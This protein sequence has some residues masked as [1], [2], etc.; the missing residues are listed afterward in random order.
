M[1]S[2]EKLVEAKQ[3][4]RE[5][6]AHA[7]RELRYALRRLRHTSRESELIEFLIAMEEAGALACRLYDTTHM[8][9]FLWF[10]MADNAFGNYIFD[11]EDDLTADIVELFLCLELDLEVEVRP[12]PKLI[13]R[14]PA[15]TRWIDEP[16]ER[17]AEIVVAN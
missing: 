12:Q 14:K 8:P 11:L 6:L 7:H 16:D 3:I 17:V 15:E 13:W 10:S 2:L 1:G 9:N 4:H 5:K